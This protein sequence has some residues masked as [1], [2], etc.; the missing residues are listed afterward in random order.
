M[1]GKEFRN[2]KEKYNGLKMEVVAFEEGIWTAAADPASTSNDG[3]GRQGGQ[4]TLIDPT[5]TAGYAP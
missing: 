5:G 3:G 4:N 2:M 1:A